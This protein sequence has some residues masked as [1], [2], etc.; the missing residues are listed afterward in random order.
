MRRHRGLS[1]VIAATMLSA[2]VSPGLAQQPAQPAQ[3]VQV[4]VL[5]CLGGATVGF[6]VGAVVNLRCV[7]RINGMPEDY[8]VAT[9]QKLGL[10]IGFTETTALAWNVFAPVVQPGR[11]DLA[12]TY[13]GVD[14]MAAAVVG[15]GGNVLLGGSNNSIALQPLSVQ[16]ST[17]VIIAAGVESLT[18]Q[19]GR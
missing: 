11:G 15:V 4:G 1:I 12:G 7:L 13:V 9:M 16:A 17:G 10:D 14:A 8:Y 18:L 3:K 2:L 6:L 19:P 5:E